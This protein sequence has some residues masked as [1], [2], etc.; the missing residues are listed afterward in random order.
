[1][2][3]FETLNLGKCVIKFRHNLPKVELGTQNNSVVSMLRG[4][5][6][7]QGSTECELQLNIGYYTNG[8]PE[9]VFWGRAVTHPND[10]YRKETGRLLSLTR[11]VDEA[12]RA[13]FITVA[14]SREILSAYYSRGKSFL[15]DTNVQKV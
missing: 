10:N 1:M 14:D 11:A 8:E 9:I 13:N 6:I 4:I 15:V 3:K 5:K 12:V 7:T 2:I